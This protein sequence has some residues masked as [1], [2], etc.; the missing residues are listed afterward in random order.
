[1]AVRSKKVDFSVKTVI[2]GDSGVGKTCLL[3]RYIRDYFDEALQ[4]TLGV[5][6]MAKMIDTPK[7]HIELQLWDTAGQEL[8]R[9][10]TRGYYRNSTVA[11][12]VFDLS[13]HSTFTALDRWITDVRNTAQ[14]NVIV[15]LIGNKSD[16]S[17]VREVSDEEI[18]LFATR[19]K[20]KYFEVSA[21]TGENI[22]KAITSVV[23]ELDERA[24][25][26][27]FQGPS[28]TESILYEPPVPLKPWCC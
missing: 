25:K 27:E 21:K 14:T 13:S 26:G 17:D 19:E 7:R 2:V 4:P 16:L 9:S 18:R 5:E 3:N 20:V 28:S 15:V 6:F 1:M 12:L 23:D 10:V 11:Y 24:D 22:V 8:F